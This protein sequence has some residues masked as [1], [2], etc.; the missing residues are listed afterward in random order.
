MLGTRDEVKR[1]EAEHRQGGGEGG[2]RSRH[3][4]GRLGTFT[5]FSA[6]MAAAPSG[7]LGCSVR[8]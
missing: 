3:E 4:A 7:C 5:V 1:Q 6:E 2:G 8:V